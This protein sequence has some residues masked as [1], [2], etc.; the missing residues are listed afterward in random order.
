[1]PNKSVW[2]RESHTKI[3]STAGPACDSIE[4]LQELIL[5]GVDV[6]RLNTAHGSSE[7]HQ[8]RLDRIRAA[9]KRVG[10][11]V[12]VLVDLAGPKMRLGTIPG[13]QVDLII[14]DQVTFIR[15]QETDDPHV[16]TC[17]YEPLL[18]ELEA[19][20]RV[21]LADGTVA[22]R[23]ISND[24]QRAACVVTQGGT[25]RSKQG[26]NLP[27]VKLKAAAMSDLDRANA[28]WAV[29]AGADYI[30]LSFVRTAQ[31]ILD[32]KSLIAGTKSGN[33]PHVIAKIEKPEALDNLEAIV[34]ASDGIMVAR[35]DL[36]VEVDIAEIAIVQKRIVAACHRARKPVIIATQMLDSMHHSRIPTRAEATDVANA[37]LDGADACMLSGETAIG[38]YPVQAVEMMH[39][40]A[41]STEPLLHTYSRFTSDDKHPTPGVSPI[42]DAAARSAGRLAE[43]LGAKLVIVASSTGRAALSLSKNRRFVPTIGVSD[44]LS[45]LRRMCL[46]WGVIPV[47]EAP[48]HEDRELLDYVIGRALEAGDLKKGDRI[49][50]LSG[51]GLPT[52]RHNVVL[53]HEV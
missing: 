47:P 50:L 8:V 23:V 42:T 14:G 35:G 39:R 3:V 25:L 2:K 17:V 26:V 16:L 51:T 30:S 13:G 44:S 52:S 33:A 15:G 20:N 28:V 31:D 27:G 53:V 29:G 37:I 19:E 48:A 45:S 46:Y 5:A 12:A 9:E 6:F 40:I 22:L 43:E 36:G 38:E 21:M 18:D 49:I 4:K 34:A 32:L 10:Q 41:V 7:Q 24:G 1:M 11:P